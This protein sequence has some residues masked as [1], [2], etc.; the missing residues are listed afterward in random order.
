MSLI[1]I[2]IGSVADPGVKHLNQKNNKQRNSKRNLG[3][4]NM[5]FFS[6][7]VIKFS[8]QRNI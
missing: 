6:K 7:S 4:E 2:Y 1:L 8:D 5:N 3:K